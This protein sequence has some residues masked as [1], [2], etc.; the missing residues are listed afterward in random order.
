MRTCHWPLLI[1]WVFGHTACVL[2][3]E[4]VPSGSRTTLLDTT[5]LAVDQDSSM[6]QLDAV[7]DPFVASK[8]IAGAV[9]LVADKQGVLALRD[10]GWAD[11]EHA[12]PMSDDSIFWI[13]S[14]SKPITAACIMMLQDEGKLSLDEPITKH[15]PEMSNLKLDDGT[16]AVI[17][18]R[19][20][21]SHTSGMGELGPQEIYTSLNLEQAAERYSKVKMLFKPGSKWQYCQTGINTAGRIVEVVSGLSLDQF[22]EQ[23]L[24]QPL[25]MPDTTFYLSSAQLPRLAK[26]YRRS[27]SGE[28]EEA[29]IF[30]LVGQAP[31]DTQRMPAANGGLFSTAADYGKFCRML[32]NEGEL[33]GTRILSAKSVE[34]MRTIVTG[35][36]VTGF[37]PGNGWGIGCCV[38]REPQGVT[39]ALSSGS[40]GHGGAYGTQAWIDPVKQRVY[41]L[42]TQRANFPNAD[43]SAVR[44][45]FQEVASHMAR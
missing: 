6:A 30:L 13:A 33:E 15:L 19:Q 43:D 1:L 36:L 35:D 21:L 7:I 25:G 9:V 34:T 10:Y 40:F 5:L 41:I 16:P 44:R 32:L 23:R 38:V 28:L 17:S 42:M 27:E 24:C 31:T 12:K 22:I 29:D 11:I 20:L 2:S 45:E 3:Q 39:G 26:S 37:T 14:M 8:E 18:I 4:S